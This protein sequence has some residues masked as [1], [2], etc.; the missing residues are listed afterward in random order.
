MDS[1]PE[2]KL[3]CQN[4]PNFAIDTNYYQ[5]L[6]DNQNLVKQFIELEMKNRDLEDQL[7]KANIKIKNLNKM[8][9]LE[10]WIPICDYDLAL[11][12]HNKCDYSAHY[13]NC[14][15][16]IEIY[17]SASKF[18]PLHEK[19]QLRYNG[20]FYKLYGHTYPKDTF[21]QNNK[22]KIWTSEWM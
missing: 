16:F 6:E 5:L 7:D 15:D 2:F 13:Y 14:H 21:I 3:W 22:V 18:K 10:L 20:K 11:C 1:F 9:P 19:H 12:N 4:Y 8:I 17:I